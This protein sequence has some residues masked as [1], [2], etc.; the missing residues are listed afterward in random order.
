MQPRFLG[1]MYSLCRLGSGKRT[2]RALRTANWD[3]RWALVAST[4]WAGEEW[5]YFDDEEARER[6]LPSAGVGPCGR[7]CGRLERIKAVVGGEWTEGGGGALSA[8]GPIR[9]LGVRIRWQAHLPEWRRTGGGAGV[10]RA[11]RGDVSPAQGTAE[12]PCAQKGRQPLAAPAQRRRPALSRPSGEGC[13]GTP[14]RA[15][16]AGGRTRPQASLNEAREASS[17]ASH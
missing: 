4:T 14:S 1:D 6:P 13:G 7:V 9:D 12:D 16:A 8:A 5:N 2:R 15:G 10:R 11:L 17:Y 3:P